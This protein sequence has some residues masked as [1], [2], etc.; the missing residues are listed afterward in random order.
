[1][2]D[3]RALNQP[4]WHQRHEANNGSYDGEVTVKPAMEPHLPSPPEHSTGIS[5]LMNAIMQDEANFGTSMAKSGC[6]T[7]GPT[8][9]SLKT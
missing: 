8:S 5:E 6:S 9:G 2:Y 3:F 7:T 4:G 1:M